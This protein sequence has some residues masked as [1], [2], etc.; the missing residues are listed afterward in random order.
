MTRSLVDGWNGL[1]SAGVDHAPTPLDLHGGASVEVVAGA[2]ELHTEPVLPPVV[3]NAGY[4]G[5]TL[6]NR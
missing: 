5:T 6:V 2:L 3:A 4:P 1:L